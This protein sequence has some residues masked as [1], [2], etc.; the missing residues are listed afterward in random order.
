MP[1]DY[2][3][4]SLPPSV[5]SATAKGG[6]GWSCWDSCA[7][8]VIFIMDAKSDKSERVCVEIYH[9]LPDEKGA[10]HVLQ[11]GAGR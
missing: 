5:Y 11:K 7:P 1:D 10:I 4:L 8:F 3:P 9:G 6:E 2:L